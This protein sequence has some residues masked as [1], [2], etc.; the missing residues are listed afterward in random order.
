MLSV[1]G[2]KLTTYRRIALGALAALRPDLGLRRVDERPRPLPG[3]RD[4]EATSSLLATRFP[5]LDPS[6]R[7][8]LV[9][10]YGALADEVTAPALERPELLKRLHPDAPDIVAQGVYAWEREWAVREDD[11]LARRTT[12]AL[13]G[14]SVTGVAALAG[15]APS[16]PF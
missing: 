1:A 4:L 2:G 13:R 10:L 3:A 7:A 14:L 12:V 9:H 15:A 11:V 6:A 16:R 8:H 5:A